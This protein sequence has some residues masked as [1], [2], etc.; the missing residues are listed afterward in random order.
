VNAHRHP[1]E[2]SRGSP[3]SG[4]TAGGWPRPVPQPVDQQ[5]RETRGPLPDEGDEVGQG[6]FLLA[7]LAMLAI[8]AVMAT[9][10]QLLG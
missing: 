10:A 9:L 3:R 2:R 5:R 8:T 7:A 1:F 6:V 4:W